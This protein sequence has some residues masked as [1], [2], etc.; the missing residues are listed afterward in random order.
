MCEFIFQT[1][2]KEPGLDW[3]DSDRLLFWNFRSTH[4]KS[5]V[6]GAPLSSIYGLRGSLESEPDKCVITMYPFAKKGVYHSLSCQG[7]GNSI[8]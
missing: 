4:A 7:D 5:T 3:N 8:Y 6:V 2:Y 1:V